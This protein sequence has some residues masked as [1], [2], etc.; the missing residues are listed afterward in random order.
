MTE[1]HG[2]DLQPPTSGWKSREDAWYRLASHP[3]FYPEC[4]REESS[5]I[6]AM[7][8]KLDSMVG[9]A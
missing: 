2:D 4:Y 1:L 5:L 6:D 3:F 8:A 9:A 7:I